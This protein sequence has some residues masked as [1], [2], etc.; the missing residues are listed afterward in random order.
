MT[1]YS[2]EIDREIITEAL[3]HSKQRMNYEYDRFKLPESSRMNMVLIGTIGQLIFRKFLNKNN[4]EHSF[5]YLAD[6]IWKICI[7]KVFSV[8]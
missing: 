8:F 4:I 5:E 6:F 3:G 7:P 2:T 1:V